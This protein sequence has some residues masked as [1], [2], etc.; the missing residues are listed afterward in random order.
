[1]SDV[2]PPPPP[3]PAPEALALAMRAD[4]ARLHRA[5]HR[6]EQARAAGRPHDRN[7]RRLVD[8]LDQSRQRRA[9]RAA[10]MPR[11]SF[12]ADLP[13]ASHRA[14]IAGALERHQVIVVCG[15]TGSGKS[16]Q[17]P[18]ILLEM[19]Y[20]VDGLIGHT[21]PRRIAARSLAR[22]VAEELGSPLG[23]DVGFKV[24]F[25]DRTGAG[26]FV[27]FMTDGVLLAE[28]RRD[29][30]LDAYD[31][32]IL[33]EA[34]ERSLNIDFLLG[35]L[36]RLVSRRPE[37]RLIVTS[38]TIDPERFARH[39]ARSGQPAPVIEVSGRTY[40]VD[41][42]YRP[43]R[44]GDGE[45]VDTGQE[46]VTAVEEA[47]RRGPGDAL[48]FLPTQRDIGEVARL[49]RGRRLPGGS[50]AVLPLYAR[51]PEG[52][53]QRIFR[54][55]GGRRIVLATNVAESSV[56][57]PG[58][59]YVIDA[60]TAR[61]S[62]YSAR[63]RIQRLP[64]EA[65]SRASADQRA[66]RCGRVGP[67]TCY[68]L[69]DRADYEAREAFTQP[70]IQRSNLAA[71]VLQMAS[72]RL[73]RV[74]DFPFLDPP[75]KGMVRDG[76][77]TLRELGALDE[78]GALT[79]VGRQLA[80]LPV[81][82]RIGRM[83]LASV[84]AGCLADVLV[85]AAALETNDPRERPPGREEAADRAHAAFEDG[86]SDFASFLSMWDFMHQLRGPAA[87]GER[88]SRRE[89][90][91]RLQARFLS[92]NRC[93]EWVDVHRQL[94]ELVVEAGWKPAARGADRE[95][96]HRALLAGLLS[97][98][99]VRTGKYVYTGADGKELYVWP[100]STLFERKPKWIVAA[101]MVETAKRYARVV[102]RID[103][104]DAE[105][106][107][108]HLVE[109]SYKDPEWDRPSGRVLAHEKVSL[110][111]LPIIPRRRAPFDGVDPVLSRELFIRHG[112]V[113]GQLDTS[114]PFLAHNM[115]LVNEVAALEA[116]AR[117]RDLLADLETRYD[118][119]DRRL[120]PD[121]THAAA[122]HRWRKLAERRDP[123]VLFMSRGDLLRGDEAELG[124]TIGVEAYPDGLEWGGGVFPLRYRLA[125]GE[126][127]DGVT[128]T[129]SLDDL[130]RL[131]A[132]RLEWLVPGQLREKV[133]A[134]I[135]SLPK[136]LRRKLVPVPERADE[137]MATIR[138]ATGSLRA[139]LAELLQRYAGEPV[140]RDAFELE[141]LPEHL[142]MRIEVVGRDGRVVAH[143]RDL[144]A[145]REQLGR[146]TQQIV[147]DVPDPAWHRDGLTTW[148]FGSLPETVRLER[149][150]LVVE[151]YPAL[152][153][154]TAAAGKPSVSLRL[155][156]RRE[157][158]R[159][160]TRLGIRRLVSVAIAGRVLHRLHRCAGWESMVLQHA[161]LGSTAELEQQV[162]A[163]VAELAFLDD[164]PVRDQ[165]SFRALLEVGER[166]M[167]AVFDDVVTRFAAVL[168]A[169][170]RAR[171]VLDEARARA[172]QAVAQ[173][174]G[175]LAALASP[176]W[177]VSTAWNWLAHVPRYMRAVER[178]IER[179]GLRGS[180]KDAEL[181]A[182]L[183]PQLARCQQ[184]QRLALERDLVLPEL[185]QLH[186]MIEEYRVSIFAQEL[187]TA[188]R[189]SPKRLD[190]QFRRAEQALI[191]GGD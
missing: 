166:R 186:W 181:V 94:R 46:V 172:P 96:V 52:Q 157:L 66:G 129:V 58:I 153:D 60:G 155:R 95:A 39:F 109:R 122:L 82:P 184:L 164:D 64:V 131:D 88:L 169:V 149:N 38:A 9:E 83:I 183:A 126:P 28:T 30:A 187:G 167:S 59:R 115:S 70:E 32:I 151:V 84:D 191:R 165:D 1:M 112:L 144:A 146:D 103:P 188:L 173:I 65:I 136:P 130:D 102:G 23:A 132:T 93:R 67:G 49:L 12:P 11:P 148:D 168:S 110:Y 44:A 53:Q 140:S 27:K 33:D 50:A 3:L 98:L 104:R 175:Q 141:R 139:A 76:Q 34:H 174:D 40:P 16:T 15:E 22:R 138:F 78:N 106:L 158:A 159:R 171:L 145:L 7:L 86:D 160:E 79:D 179:L 17:L 10:R 42:V 108:P 4:R 74:E 2:S 177:L 180:S 8:E 20:G 37:L 31:A 72:L 128:L 45:E 36:K 170:Q 150:G 176:G 99:A 161:T 73:G 55:G 178:R 185:E 19:G 14:A 125:P 29:R 63:G 69:Y 21:Q 62:R 85:I 100:G 6:V 143:G 91:L 182:Q 57:V 47:V 61:V 26:T 123:D 101:E 97:H 77:R 25:T 89:Q 121:V 92:P 142:H 75:K 163:R 111:G 107:A 118:F 105:P 190:E 54:T 90:A 152:V 18:K 80:R 137:V 81:D 113:E 154:A 41:V 48:V 162:V 13:I 135:R 71:V 147:E 114:A 87:D 119:Y 117:R 43:P 116:K 120:P 51:L 35:Y 156:P 24:R 127:N 68:R 134:L 133:V 5:L 56:T 189:V 124:A